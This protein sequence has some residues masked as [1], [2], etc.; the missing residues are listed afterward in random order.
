MGHRVV[1]ALHLRGVSRERVVDAI[2]ERLAKDG[3]E[4]VAGMET[5]SPGDLR[6]LV[7]R[8]GATVLVAMRA[9]SLRLASSADAWGPEEWAA[10]LS[11]AV[12]TSTLV[13]RIPE[14]AHG[15]KLVRFERGE[16]L[17]S[18]QLDERTAGT[19]ERRCSID[20]SVL[21][22]GKKTKI[23]F[24]AEID[25]MT[26]ALGAALDVPHAWLNP[27]AEGERTEGDE[28][29][30][31]RS[32]APLPVLPKGSPTWTGFEPE[33]A[34]YR[35]RQHLV[36]EL[37]F[38]DRANLAS[39]AERLS[40]LLHAFCP[41]NGL[42]VRASRGAKREVLA[43]PFTRT[44]SVRLERM[45]GGS[46][47]L[48]STTRFVPLPGAPLFWIDC[49]ANS[50][51]DDERPLRFGACIVRPGADAP[52]EAITQALRTLFEACAD[53][54]GCVSG[55]LTAQGHERTLDSRSFPYEALV[56]E[57]A[58]ARDLRAQTAWLRSHVKSPGWLVLVP[59]AGVRG[60]SK[61]VP[62]G[63]TVERTRSGT[64]VQLDAPTPF[65][66]TKTEPMERWLQPLLG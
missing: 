13:L 21:G 20:A 44:S 30:V 6:L 2:V 14:D 1:N 22:T 24:E 35:G 19:N 34:A 38:D 7:R 15:T 11:T 33:V 43:A 45:R 9:P 57:A 36:L 52:E 61:K 51:E 56:A 63:L 46:V 8:A 29:F 27:C 62:D 64:L 31:F 42:A 58:E 66:M 53:L 54:E 47:E 65:V 48:S 5:R 32:R 41:T 50:S 10:H 28:L 17:A 40:A 39:V 25:A 37:A 23:V 49:P 59:T 55:I 60:L 4:H 3:F 12:A 26:E 16:E 18:F